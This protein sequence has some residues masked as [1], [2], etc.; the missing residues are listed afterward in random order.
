MSHSIRIYSIQ[1]DTKIK[2]I[3]LFALAKKL[4]ALGFDYSMNVL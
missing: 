3:K 1:I 4:G 2:N